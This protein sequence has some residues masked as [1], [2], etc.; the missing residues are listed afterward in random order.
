[1]SKKTQ[2]RSNRECKLHVMVKAR[3]NDSLMAN[4]FDVSRIYEKDWNM[5]NEL[6]N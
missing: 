6:P 4:Q 2:L 1:M 5:W 3:S